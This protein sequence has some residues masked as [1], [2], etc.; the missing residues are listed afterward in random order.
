MHSEDFKLI[1][2]DMERLREEVLSRVRTV[3]RMRA[4][5]ASPFS[6]AALAIIFVLC[7]S[8]FVSFGDVVHNIMAHGEW[9]GRFSY[10]YASLIHTRIAVQ[11]LAVL[12]SVSCLILFTKILF[13]LRSPVYFIGNFITSHTSRKLFRS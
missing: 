12:T 9:S 11:I 1:T 3:R 5:W 10:T 13:R 7:A 4:F 6:S 8:I 2:E